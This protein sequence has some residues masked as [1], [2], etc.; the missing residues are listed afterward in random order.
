[1]A[2]QRKVRF[3]NEK[4]FKKLIDNNNLL[5][6]ELI[7]YKNGGEATKLG[8]H[9]LRKCFRKKMIEY[10]HTSKFI[11]STKFNKTNVSNRTIDYVEVI[12]F[13]KR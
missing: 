12:R 8:G 3:Y 4:K 5:D 13:T 10:L 9:L 1:M 6:F 7:H 11:I 2:S